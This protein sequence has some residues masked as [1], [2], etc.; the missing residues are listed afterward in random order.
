M[1]E[2]VSSY[3]DE[4]KAVANDHERQKQFRQFV[5]TVSLNNLFGALAINYYYAQGE[6][7][8]TI[9]PII[10][11]GQIRPA[12]WSKTNAQIYLQQG[13]I[14]SPKNKWR[15]RKLAS[16]CDLNPTDIGTT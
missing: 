7:I 14:P 15:W 5:N 16:V 8:A 9:E 3:H 4:W 2:L 6:R 11:R 10:E 12:D 1:D 13:D